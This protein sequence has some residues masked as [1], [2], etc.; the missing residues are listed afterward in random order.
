[1]TAPKKRQ[2]ITTLQNRKTENIGPPAPSIHK[3][4]SDSLDLYREEAWLGRKESR[5]LTE[6][7]LDELKACIELGFGF[8]MSTPKIDRRLPDAIPALEL[9]YTVNKQYHDVVFTVAWDHLA[10]LTLPFN[11]HHPPN[12]LPDNAS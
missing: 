11:D 7:D 2:C 3:Q 10:H 1:M 12:M 4:N 9:Y 6:E 8:E 5:S